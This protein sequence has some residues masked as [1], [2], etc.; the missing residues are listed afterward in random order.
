VAIGARPIL[1]AYNVYLTTPDV[2]VA[3]RI[4][5]EVR[6]SLE[7]RDGSL[8]IQLLVD[9]GFSQAVEHRL[10][11]LHAVRPNAL[12][13]AAHDW[14]RF[15]QVIDSFAHANIRRNLDQKDSTQ[16]ESTT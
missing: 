15:L 14:V 11:K 7:N 6:K 10:A 1:I 16:W 3:K 4:A 13:D 5:R 8:A 9:D 12:N 2:A